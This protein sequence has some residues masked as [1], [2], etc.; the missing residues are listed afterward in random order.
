VCGGDA[1]QAWSLTVDTRQG[2]D[3]KLGDWA[4]DNN[5]S[6]EKPVMLRN[7]VQGIGL[8]RNFLISLQ[9]QGYACI[10]M[11]KVVP[12][13]KLLRPSCVIVPSEDDMFHRTSEIPQMTF[14]SNK[15]ECAKCSNRHDRRRSVTCWREDAEKLWAIFTN[16]SDESTA[17]IFRAEEE[18]HLP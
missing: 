10:S 8:E 1:L 9:N 14:N 13:S 6:S 12:I 2:I 17:P 11:L 3:I 4:W 7:A 15:E 16:I 5:M 18:I